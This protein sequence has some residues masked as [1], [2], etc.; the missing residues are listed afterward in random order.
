M[1]SKNFSSTYLWRRK[2]VKEKLHY[3]TN[4][5]SGRWSNSRIRL[6]DTLNIAYMFCQSCISS[7]APS[8]FH[9]M[10]GAKTPYS[11]VWGMLCGKH[12][13]THTHTHVANLPQSPSSILVPCSQPFSQYSF[14]A[15]VSMW[16]HDFLYPLR[17]SS[18]FSL[19]KHLKNDNFSAYYDIMASDLHSILLSSSLKVE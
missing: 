17:T 14:H 1:R 4:F 15:G 2:P 18:S 12:T 19:G 8:E 9:E 16:V 10:Q 7:H 3:Q 13:H 6:L 11:V 5:S